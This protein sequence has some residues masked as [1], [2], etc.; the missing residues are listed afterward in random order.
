[1][2]VVAPSQG[3]YVAIGT[4]PTVTDQNFFVTTTDDEVFSLGIVESQRVVGIT[5]EPTTFLTSQKEL[6]VL[7][8]SEV[9]R[10][11]DSRWYS[12]SDFEHKFFI[13]VLTFI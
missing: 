4:E 5:T 7:L 2:R 10:E 11:S 9:L 3:V 8:V 6:V 1:M 13:N 12:Y